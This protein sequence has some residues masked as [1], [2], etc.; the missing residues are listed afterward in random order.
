MNWHDI[1]T[2]PSKEWYRQS[3]L[4]KPDIPE[5]WGVTSEEAVAR[6]RELRDGADENYDR[7][8]ARLRDKNWIVGKDTRLNA[9][10]AI[11][12][13]QEAVKRLRGTTPQ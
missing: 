9:A 1:V 3:I 2:Q 13:L 10:D 12:E 11:E 7:L 5:G 8:I 6:I 4:E